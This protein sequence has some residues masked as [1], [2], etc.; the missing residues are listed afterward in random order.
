MYIC[1]IFNYIWGVFINNME[2]CTY[3]RHNAVLEW[4]WHLVNRKSF[5]L[6]DNV[7]VSLYYVS[8]PFFFQICI[9]SNVVCCGPYNVIHVHLLRTQGPLGSVRLTVRYVW[10]KLEP[11]LSLK[12]N[13]LNNLLDIF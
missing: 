1:A 11:L 4:E 5:I 6:L 13:N 2:R 3:T 12:S 9:C 10:I 8:M 7:F